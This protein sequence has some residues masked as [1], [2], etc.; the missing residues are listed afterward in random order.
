MLYY[1]IV[2]VYM[3]Y[4]YTTKTTVRDV[5]E[6]FWIKTCYIRLCRARHVFEDKSSGPSSIGSRR[7]RAVAT[8][9][10]RYLFLI[11]IIFVLLA[12]CGVDDGDEKI[13][14]KPCPVSLSERG[15]EK[16][17]SG[18]INR[19]IYGRYDLRVFWSRQMISWRIIM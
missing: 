2:V 15:L 5:Q 4:G 18:S 7:R 9:S 14:R 10:F 8:N 17:V 11:V 16:T 6:K 12:R 19:F 1:I 13:R 3:E